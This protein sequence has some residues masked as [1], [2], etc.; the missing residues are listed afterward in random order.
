MNILLVGHV[1]YDFRDDEKL[2]GG[3]P[4]YSASYLVNKQ[5]EIDIL[6]SAS[7]NYPFPN[8]PN[9]S[10]LNIKSKQTTIYE[11]ITPSH[12]DQRTLKLVSKAKN[13]S[14]KNLTRQKY[15]AIIISGI[16]GEVD[17]ELI[18]NLRNRTDLLVIDIQTLIRDFNENR[19]MFTINE[20]EL[21]LDWNLFDIIKISDD[22]MNELKIR[23]K[24]LILYTGKNE[25]LI[26]QGSKSEKFNFQPFNGKVVDSTGSGDI[27]LSVFVYNLLQDRSL[28]EC[29]K[30]AR[31]EVESNLGFKGPKLF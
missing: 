27:F 29:V 26:K 10:V 15:D 5:V 8:Y 23:C 28:T 20:N 4:L 16:A 30:L 2:V 1:C 7:E 22:E 17:Q 25:L 14:S 31:K 11:Y 19:I 24:G 13:L 21:D 3:P 18:L 6:T 9:L 12:K